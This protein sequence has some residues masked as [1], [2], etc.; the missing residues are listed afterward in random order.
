[1]TNENFPSYLGYGLL[2][3]DSYRKEAE[4]EFLE[5]CYNGQTVLAIELSPSGAMVEEY[6][7]GKGT[8]MSFGKHLKGAVFQHYLAS[9]QITSPLHLEWI[10][11]VVSIG[12][13]YAEMIQK[14]NQIVLYFPAVY[15]I[16]IKIPIT[17]DKIPL[18][19]SFIKDEDVIKLKPAVQKGTIITRYE[20]RNENLTVS[21]LSI[22]TPIAFTLQTLKRI[23]EAGLISTEKRLRGIVGLSKA[24]NGTII[25]NFFGSASDNWKSYSILYQNTL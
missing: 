23:K 1:M 15:L 8:S 13:I 25:R 12:N 17:D 2:N 3:R 5:Y 14:S 19:E 24:S 21:L 18:L 6:Y 16:D 11:E 22:C 10:R 9:D 4:K 7:N 20:D